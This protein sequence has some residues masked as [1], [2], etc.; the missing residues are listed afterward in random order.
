MAKKKKLYIISLSF[1]IKCYFHAL[2][3]AENANFAS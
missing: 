2:N 3:R 1:L